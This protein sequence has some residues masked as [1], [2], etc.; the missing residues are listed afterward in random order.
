MSGRLLHVGWLVVVWVLLWGSTAPAVLA[1]GLLVAPLCLALCRLPA[2]RLRSR[3][4]AVA[5]LRALGRF[6][7]DQAT[8]TVAVART[9]LRRGPA[10]RSAVVAVR[11]PEQGAPP[12]DLLLSTVADRLSLVPATLVVDVDRPS[13]T[14]YVYVLDVDDDAG[15]DAARADAARAVAEVLAAAGRAVP[16][17]EG[18]P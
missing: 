11:L 8:S 5:S 7:A 17:A 1:S 14:L 15:V 3:P 18:R 6:V 10:T 4:R 13:G 16:D 2:V 9:V 12:S